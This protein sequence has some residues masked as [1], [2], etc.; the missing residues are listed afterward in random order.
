MIKKLNKTHGSLYMPG[1]AVKT[2]REEA[3]LLIRY[4]TENKH[5]QILRQQNR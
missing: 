1:V 5:G 2:A 3:K 4:S